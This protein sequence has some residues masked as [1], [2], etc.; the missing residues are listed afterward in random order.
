M[1][2][3]NDRLLNQTSSTS[4]IHAAQP[5]VLYE[6]ITEKKRKR[7]A[8]QSRQTVPSQ[9]QDEVREHV[10]LVG[11]TPQSKEEEDD[12]VEAKVDEA[13]LPDH[14][15]LSTESIGNKEPQFFLVKPRTSSSRL[16]LIPLSST[17]TLGECLTGRSV[18]EF[19]TIHVFPSPLEHLPDGF[20]LEED[21]LKQ[22]S[23][24]QKEFNEL[25]S[26]LDPKILKRLTE[27]GRQHGSSMGK[28]ERVDDKEI[29]D[30]LKKD[31]GNVL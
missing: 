28:E 9:S 30:V 24:E 1:D 2:D 10:P 11:R 21:Y 15:K 6:K 22:E 4:Q 12:D 19:P 26:E 27:D 8:E 5:F 13:H 25:I 7:N 20:M 17:A 29:L 3:N 31:F 23:E 14:E 18:L 16:V